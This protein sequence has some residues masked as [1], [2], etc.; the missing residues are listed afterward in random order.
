MTD[1]PYLRVYAK[2][3]G[4]Y[5]SPVAAIL[6]GESLEPFVDVPA[7]ILPLADDVHFF[8][9]ILADV[10]FPEIAGHRVERESPR[11]RG[12]RTLQISGR[13]PGLPTNGLS[14]G[15]EYPLPGSG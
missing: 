7:V 14:F 10:T 13:T 2:T 8:V 9:E 15:T 4:T 6:V 11:L 12:G 5:F 3:G 1:W